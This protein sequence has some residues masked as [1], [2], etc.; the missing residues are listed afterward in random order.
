MPPF[1]FG[2]TTN[3]VGRQFCN[4]NFKEKGEEEGEVGDPRWKGKNWLRRAYFAK[5]P[6]KIFLFCFPTSFF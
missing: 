6:R 1:Q 2:N 4:F 3:Y 5:R